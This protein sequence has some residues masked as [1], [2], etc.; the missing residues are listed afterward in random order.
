MLID[1]HV[2]LDFPEFVQLDQVLSRAFANGVHEMVT[3]GIDPDSSRKAVALAQDHAEIHATVGLHPHGAR[4][5][6][7]S[8]VEE[9]RR[10]GRHPRVVA[11][12]EIGL[13]YYRDRQPRDTQQ[14]CLRQ[15][16]ELAVE[17]GL[18]V[19]IH[20]RDAY[21]DFLGII[22]DYARLL[23]GLVL[24]CF[25]GDWAVARECL[26]LGGYLSIPGTVTYAKAQ[27]QQEVVR[28]APLDRLLLETDAPFLAPVPYR[29]KSNEPAYLLHT[30][31]KV[32]ELRGIRLADVAGSTT[33][34]A[35]AVFH[36]TDRKGPG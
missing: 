27:I 34:N 30:A 15:Q 31:E 19:V 2:H 25:S 17:L 7:Q 8:M 13:D 16:L 21:D 36:L 29:G 12:G 23:D 26:D 3:I 35:R 28:K 4:I 18:P 14:Q 9:L 33:A 22:R 20:V 24:H 32:A 10:L 1:T 5:L 11:I 6:D